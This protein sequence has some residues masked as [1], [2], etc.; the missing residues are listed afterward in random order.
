MTTRDERDEVKYND[1]R[2]AGEGYDDEED[3]R[4][5][6]RDT[7]ASRAPGMFF[8]LSFLYYCTI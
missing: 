3:E 1:D 7:S 4:L 6:T 2:T 5:G 8:F